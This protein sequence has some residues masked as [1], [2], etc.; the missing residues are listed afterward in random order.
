[1]FRWSHLSIVSVTTGHGTSLMAPS[2]IRNTI[3]RPL[4]MRPTQ[5][6]G[7]ATGMAAVIVVMIVSRRLEWLLGY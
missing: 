4:R 3:T 1:V 6:A 5:R 7:F 2:S